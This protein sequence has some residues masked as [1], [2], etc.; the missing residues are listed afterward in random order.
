MTAPF[1]MLALVTDA[2]GGRGGM[3][4]YNR[5]FLAS[6]AQ[7]AMAPSITVLPRYAPDR[8]APPGGVRQLS[9]RPGR[10]T[11]ILAALRT[12]LGRR[13]DVVFCG[14]MYMAPLA[15]LLAR[16]K[17]AKLVIQMHGIEAWPQPTRL[18]RAAVEAADLVLCV[19]RHTRAQVLNWAAIAPDRVLVLP[20]TVGEAF[21]PGDGSSLRA[22]WDL[23]GKCVLLSVGRMDACER[24]KGHDRVIAAMPRLVAEGHD[25][26]YVVV[27][28]GDD[29]PRLKALAVETGVADRVRF[30]GAV[31]RETLI[32][33]YH[34]ADLFVMPSTGEGFGIAFLEAMASGTPALGLAV[35]GACD[36]LA[37]GELGAAVAEPELVSTLVRLLAQS[38]P[39]SD[40]LAAAVRGRFGHAPFAA[41]ARAALDRLMQ[42]A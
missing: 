33:A 11:Y 14:H 12:A 15:L 27:G 38:K 34:M 17:R 9:P 4:Q 37:D 6:L 31:G 40:A 1:E 42:A 41:G 3:A 32:G 23:Q 24:Y 5:D 18:R 20:N 22:A 36:A 30:M 2:F 29:L 10:A 39:N 13:V 26:V 19:S 7:C 8:S 21:S 16:L 28:D 35:A 25:V